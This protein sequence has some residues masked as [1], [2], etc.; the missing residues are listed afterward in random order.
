MEDGR[1]P[2]CIVSLGNTDFYISTDGE[3]CRCFSIFSL[4]FK[5]VVTA[6]LVLRLGASMYKMVFAKQ[7]THD[8]III[9]S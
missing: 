7:T 6:C 9:H 4:M 3:A 8:L 2:V 5:V 1:D